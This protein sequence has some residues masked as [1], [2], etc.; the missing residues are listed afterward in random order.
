MKD[1]CSFNLQAHI[2]AIFIIVSNTACEV[3]RLKQNQCVG[4][5]IF[6]VKF[7]IEQNRKDWQNSVSDISAFGRQFLILWISNS[8]NFTT[9]F[10][11]STWIMFEATGEWFWLLKPWVLYY[12][13]SLSIW[14]PV[15][16][17]YIRAIY[18]LNILESSHP[19]YYV[20]FRCLDSLVALY[21]Q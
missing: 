13:P 18:M 7:R 19:V 5:E 11:N 10:S 16:I 17:W 2:W 12:E 14:V 3:S 21:L 4:K 8:T 20:Y 9:W 6:N 1:T 15:F